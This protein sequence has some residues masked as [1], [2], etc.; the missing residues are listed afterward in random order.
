MSDNSNADRPPADLLRGLTGYRISRRRAIQ[1]G[2]LS[3]VSVALAAC[4]VEGAKKTPS[5]AVSSAAK[6]FW[7]GK[8]K[9]GTLDFANWPLY[10]DVSEKN[11]NVHP[12]IDMFTKQTGIKV[13]YSE[14]I[15]DDPSFFGKI[16]PQLAAGQNIGYDII[17]IT[18]G[19][20]LD[21]LK[22]LDYLQALDQDAMK[23]F[24]ANASDLVKN[25]S[26]DKGNTYTMAWQSGMT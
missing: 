9:T 18:N 24:Y 7:D 6:S 12:S 10:I 1:L 23:N 25:P 14:V 11:K 5:S 2:G 26:Y 4:G 19:T 20:Y 17:V 16:Q 13:K 15:Q 3:A 21:K 8:K 22:Q